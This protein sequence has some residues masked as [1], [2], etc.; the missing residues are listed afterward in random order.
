MSDMKTNANVERKDEKKADAPPTMKRTSS[1]PPSPVDTTAFKPNFTRAP[2]NV[3]VQ[4]IDFSDD[5]H[6]ALL[7]AAA[8]K[9]DVQKLSALLRSGMNPNACNLD[10][11]SGTSSLSFLS[12]LVFLSLSHVFRFNFP[13][14]FLSS[15]CL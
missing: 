2:S 7:L 1:I 5:A 9:N 12:V 3:T 10:G 8:A 11:R 4:G 13:F 15:A 6:I 14:L